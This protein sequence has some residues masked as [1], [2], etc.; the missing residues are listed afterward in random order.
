MIQ[1]TY[2]FFTLD[3]L[4]SVIEVIHSEA[5]YTTASGILMQL[6]NARLDIDEELLV[7]SIFQAFPSACISGI[8]SA[9][10][11]GDKFDLTD[12]PI[13][14]SVTFF[15][16]TTLIQY[17][18]NMDDFTAF[19][20][21]RIMNELMDEMEDIKCLQIFYST[22]SISIQTFM[23]EFSH[24]KI[25][26][27]GVKAGRSITRKNIA[28]VYGNQVY[29]NGFVVIVF[30]SKN[31]KI[32]M[33]NN[34]GWQPI[35]TEM[36][37]TETLG[38]NIITEIDK[39]PATEIY[40]KYLKVSPNQY[41]VENVCEFPLIIDRDGMQIARVPAAC[42]EDGAIHLTSDIYTGDHFR[43]SYAI[44]DRLLALTRESV[45]DLNAFSPEAVYL[46]E[47]G[48]RLRFLGKDFL[49]EIAQYYKYYDQLSIVT[50]YAELFFPAG[51]KGADMNSS[52]VVV[53]LKETDKGDD[54]F[55]TK[56]DPVSYS[57]SCS[58]ADKEIP[59]IDRIL[60]FLE[61]TS[62][63]LDSVNKELGKI[64]YTDQLTKIYNRWELE[65]KIDECLELNRH[66]KSY[67]LL[68]FDID[69]FKSINDTYGHDIGDMAL[70]AVVNI[71]KEFLKDDHTFGRWGGEEFIY[72]Y[73]AESTDD[74][75]GFA[76]KIRKTIDETCFITTKHITISTGATMAR[77]EDNMLSFVKRAD[78]GVY[79]AK[80]TGRNKVVLK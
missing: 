42:D 18:F 6:Y 20:A 30:L 51:G 26:V 7:E 49:K 76:E 61:S 47:C 31:L 59:F 1:K 32:Y 48:N 60:A 80:E 17:D 34:F 57:F 9:N 63:E 53:G 74:L 54:V 38:D 72:L 70:L 44:A 58:T 3:E 33:D 79:E 68:F 2:R 15:E 5:A 4:Q 64:A 75:I 52:L 27:F 23:K 24:R 8:T 35:G 73:P 11:A 40:E 62:K 13:V 67:G 16:N 21:G 22:K 28:H 10:I 12:N 77:N 37:V 45:M 14:L 55:I 19:V 78:S 56:R 25:P 50:G 66:G 69:H 41:F 71:I 65:I 39:K 46:F 36:M 29:Q 43:L